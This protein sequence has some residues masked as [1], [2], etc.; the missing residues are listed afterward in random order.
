MFG[1][2]GSAIVLLRSLACHGAMYKVICF[3]PHCARAIHFV[4]HIVAWLGCCTS[5]G[6]VVLWGHFGFCGVMH[7]CGRWK[8][9]N[10]KQCSGWWKK[11]NI[12]DAVATPLEVASR[13]HQKIVA[14]QKR[15][16]LTNGSLHMVWSAKAFVAPD[17]IICCS[18]RN[19]SNKSSHCFQ[20]WKCSGGQ[21]L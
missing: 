8:K 16:Q 6:G 14:K 11:E 19:R 9:G 15:K 10:Y 13:S 3:V 21:L 2:T 17:A 1:A 20:K 12:N 4:P 7:G 5:C 18:Q